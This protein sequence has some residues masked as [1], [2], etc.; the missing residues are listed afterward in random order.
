MSSWSWRQTSSQNRSATTCT[1][2]GN[3]SAAARAARLPIIVGLIVI[4]IFFEVQSSAFLT[5]TNIVNLFVQATFI[6]LLGMAEL[7]ALI[8]SEI[9]LSVGFVGAVGASI[10]MALIGAPQN[11]VWWAAARSSAWRRVH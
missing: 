1:P 3:A 6:I 8:L 5:S 10:A 11:W 2:G 7:Y 9:D 4:S